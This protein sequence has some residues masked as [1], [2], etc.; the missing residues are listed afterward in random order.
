MYIMCPIIRYLTV[1]GS[2]KHMPV[3]SHSTDFTPVLK[4]ITKEADFKLRYLEFLLV[5]PDA[6]KKCAK[7]LLPGSGMASGKCETTWLQLA[8]LMKKFTMSRELVMALAQHG[9]LV[10][11]DSIELAISLSSDP[12][13]PVMLC[14]VMEN[15]KPPKKVDY[16]RLLICSLLHKRNNLVEHFLGKNPKLSNDDVWK[17]IY[18]KSPSFTPHFLTLLFQDK[19]NLSVKN[20]TGQVPVEYFLF[21][22]IWDA[23]D[24][25]LD[26][27][28]ADTSMVDLTRWIVRYRNVITEEML[29]KVI[30]CGANVDGIN[31]SIPEPMVSAITHQR[32]DLGAILLNHGADLSAVRLSASSGTTLMHLAVTL[33][34]STGVVT[35]V[36]MYVCTCVHMHAYMLCVYVCMYV[37]MYYVCMYVCMCVCM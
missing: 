33:A 12:Q 20:S 2:T 31:K 30:K 17:L 27:Y 34:L 8:D 36:C 11:E 3:V 9:T 26:T 22:G 1:A 5:K 6:S 19:A 4:R 15:L 37:C 25:L 14:N 18:W 10:M 13:V 32:S 23:S 21:Q 16:R 24:F 7:R 29:V 28:S 35:C